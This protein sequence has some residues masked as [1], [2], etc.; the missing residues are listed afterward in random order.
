MI[1]FS[2]IIKEKIFKLLFKSILK[3]SFDSFLVFCYDSM[4]QALFFFFFFFL[5]FPDSDLASQFS[6]CLYSF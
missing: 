4:L 3:S 6:N 5:A 1:F 2:K